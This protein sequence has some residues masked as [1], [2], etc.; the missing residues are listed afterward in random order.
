M[1]EL[2]SIHKV[3]VARLTDFGAFCTL[4]GSRRDGLLHI[5]QLA[6]SRVEAADLPHILEVGEEIFVKVISVDERSGKLAFSRKLA[7]QSDGRDLDPSH[8]EAAAE[9]ERRGGGGGKG[10]AT[11]SARER[12][13][14]M[15]AMN[16]PEYG[17]KQRGSGPGC[18]DSAKLAKHTPSVMHASPATPAVMDVSP[19]SPAVPASS[20]HACQRM[21][22]KYMSHEG[23][24]PIVLQV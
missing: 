8:V 1:P 19:A 6:N 9:G 11:A 16:V 7:S 20:V 21:Q 4:P 10:S 24:L 14:Q 17:G 15:A 12:D 13:S 18:A 3:E 23:T 22:C 2:Y 5:S